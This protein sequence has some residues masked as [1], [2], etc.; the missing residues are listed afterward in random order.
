M[1]LFAVNLQ[2]AKNGFP[3]RSLIIQKCWNTLETM[4]S[5]SNFG[6]TAEQFE[7]RKLDSG[8]SI[9]RQNKIRDN[10]NTR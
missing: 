8:T 10:R 4:I 1:A 9:N 3:L 5:W 6:Q 7:H 2:I